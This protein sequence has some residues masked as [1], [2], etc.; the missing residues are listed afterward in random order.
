MHAALGTD[1]AAARRDA[2]TLAADARAIE[3][4]LSL[5]AS[6][7]YA[8]VTADRRD[9]CSGG[10]S[11]ALRIDPRARL[12]W[13]YDDGTKREL[14][15]NRVDASVEARFDIG[16]AQEDVAFVD[17]GH[18]RGGF[19]CRRSEDTW[20]L[21]RI[22]YESGQRETVLDLESDERPRLLAGPGGRSL[23]IATRDG[24]SWSLALLVGETR[25]PLPIGSSAVVPA[26]EA[27]FAAF[28]P[29]G[30]LLV[31]V[32]PNPID[33]ARV[34]FV[35]TELGPAGPISTR[36][37]AAGQA[38][39]DFEISHDGARLAWISTDDAAMRR[40]LGI[41]DLSTARTVHFIPSPTEGRDVRS[42]RWSPRGLEVLAVGDLRSDGRDEAILVQPDGLLLFA[43]AMAPPQDLVIDN[44]RWSP[45]GQRV[46]WIAE[47]DS[48]R[49]LLAIEVAGLNVREMST[50]AARV[51]DFA[52]SSDGREIAWRIDVD[53]TSRIV[54]A[55]ADGN[56]R[57]ILDRT[58]AG[59][60][61]VQD[62]A[63]DPI[64]ARLAFV[65]DVTQRSV[66]QTLLVDENDA[67][68]EMSRADGTGG[69]TSAARLRWVRF[70]GTPRR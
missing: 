63:W 47:T 55:F 43:T 51:Q 66:F 69:V 38:I 42:F 24:P 22:S 58:E 9:A 53:G 45:D 12:I 29:S 18:G 17:A 70:F 1:P 30:R 39:A 44:F 31:W 54:R 4:D 14:V 5:A 26:T 37:L 19:V 50:E 28:D 34:D 56:G 16:T 32:A 15:V 62:Y 49:R 13:Q 59:H 35:L 2:R 11:E 7:F 6:G 25:V 68:R 48:A 10:T 36:R 64:R 57:R 27:R 65:A 20:T 67:V 21:E 41:A 33:P 23:A 40:S 61:G 60:D 8:E 3:T 46:A 52:W